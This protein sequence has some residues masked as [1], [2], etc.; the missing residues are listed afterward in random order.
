M[1]SITG[2]NECSR[3]NTKA[4]FKRK[5]D[6]YMYHCEKCLECFEDEEEYLIH[7]PECEY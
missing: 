3:F 5:G 4:L 7:L 2:S 1:K 6:R